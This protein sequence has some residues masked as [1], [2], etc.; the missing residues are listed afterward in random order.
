MHCHTLSNN[1]SHKWNIQSNTILLQFFS[2]PSK[3]LDFS[4]F[5]SEPW[6]SIC[7]L[8]LWWPGV[9]SVW[10]GVQKKRENK[11]YFYGNMKPSEQ[12][13][14]NLST[15]VRIKCIRI[16]KKPIYHHTAFGKKYLL[17]SLMKYAIGK[18]L[19]TFYV[20]ETWKLF[21]TWE[22]IERHNIRFT[23]F[24]LTYGIFSPR[25]QT[26]MVNTILPSVYAI[27]EQCLFLEVY[28]VQPKEN[29]TMPH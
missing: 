20:P 27:K 24:L 21:L 14:T 17:H 16:N 15:V 12:W 23:L 1:K 29:M 19:H 5:S 9:S 11:D 25:K 4:K 6:H 22:H 10:L 28:L 13:L 8:H 7:C 2:T 26:L 18:P 3:K